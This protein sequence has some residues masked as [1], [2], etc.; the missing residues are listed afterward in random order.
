MKTTKEIAE[1]CALTVHQAVSLAEIVADHKNGE[2]EEIIG[3]L[4]RRIEK[5]EEL[6][7]QCCDEPRGLV[8]AACD[9]CGGVIHPTVEEFL[10]KQRSLAN[11][12]TQLRQQT[13]SWDETLAE[14]RRFEDRI[15]KLEEE[16]AV[17]VKAL[18]S[19]SIDCQ[20]ALCDDWDRSDDGFL[21]TQDEVDGALRE[22]GEDPPT[23]EPSGG[24]DNDDEQLPESIG[25]DGSIAIQNPS[26]EK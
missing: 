16:K 2:L 18:K 7:G 22:M 21:A 19:V 11:S 5:L 4:Y 23:H 6:K 3:A 20:M 15:E 8:G 25:D 26:D 14:N 9:H 17:A 24:Y 12:I 1:D 13:K 10:A